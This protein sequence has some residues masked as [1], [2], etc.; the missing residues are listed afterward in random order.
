MRIITKVEQEKTNIIA[1]N[2]YVQQ[3]YIE[4]YEK[5]INIPAKS[6][7]GKYASF[8]VLN[9]LHYNEGL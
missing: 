9:D 3:I 7:L 5:D 1:L 2:N 8:G 6:Y 4:K